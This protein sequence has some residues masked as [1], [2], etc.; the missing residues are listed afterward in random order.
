MGQSY[1][2][3]D[4]HEDDRCVV[5]ERRGHEGRSQKH[6]GSRN[7]T[8]AGGGDDTICQCIEQPGAHEGAAED[9]HRGDRDRCGIRKNRQNSV[10][11][12]QSKNDKQRRDRRGRHLGGEPLVEEAREENQK[13]RERKIRLKGVQVCHSGVSSALTAERS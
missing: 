4:Q 9:K 7:G 1:G 10:L 11:R 13:K 6:A 12:H 2:D 3:R 5:H 8:L